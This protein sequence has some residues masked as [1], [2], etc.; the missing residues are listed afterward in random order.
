[1]IEAI[2]VIRME[3]LVAIIRSKRMGN[4]SIDNMLVQKV[5]GIVLVD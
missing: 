4:T 2:A 5:V 3:A 1:L